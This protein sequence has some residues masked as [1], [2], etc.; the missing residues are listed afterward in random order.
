MPTAFPCA[1]FPPLSV[2]KAVTIPTLSK[3]QVMHVSRLVSMLNR[4]A[5]DPKD[6]FWLAGLARETGPAIVE[7][8]ALDRL[9]APA[10][11]AVERY[12]EQPLF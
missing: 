11:T 5:E 4:L 12:T 6:G 7:L 8:G 2:P 10:R 1:P 9:S 3:A